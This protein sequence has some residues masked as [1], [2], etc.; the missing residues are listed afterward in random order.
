[1]SQ[2]AES[3]VEWLLCRKYERVPLSHV[4]VWLSGNGRV[5]GSPVTS[6]PFLYDQVSADRRG[7]P[8]AMVG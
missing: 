2:F 8:D 1:M 5:H 6:L 4:S 3:T 7:G